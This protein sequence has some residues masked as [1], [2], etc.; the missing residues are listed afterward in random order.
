MDLWNHQSYCVPPE[1]VNG[2]CECIEALFPWSLIVRRPDLIGYRLGDDLNRGALYLRPAPAASR[3]HRALARLRGAD[4]ELA[5]A[6]R[7]L[8]AEDA[9]VNDHHGLRVADVA[10]WERRVAA[11]RAL[12]AARPDLGVAVVR[13]ERPGAPGALTDYLYQAWIRLAL[14]GPLRNTFELQALEPGRPAVR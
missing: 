9:D 5:A 7:A 8:E 1:H 4:A 12:A 13:V 14:L 6:F 10:E 11:A 3:L 2:I